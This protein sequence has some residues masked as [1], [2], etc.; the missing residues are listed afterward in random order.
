MVEKG[1]FFMFVTTYRHFPRHALHTLSCKVLC[2]FLLLVICSLPAAA[3]VNDCS[4]DNSITITPLHSSTIYLEKDKT[5]LLDMYFGYSITNNSGSAINDLWVRLNNFT[6]TGS[7][8]TLATYENGVS[9]IGSLENGATKV[10]YFYVK[11]TGPSANSQSHDVSLY[12]SNP[13]AALPPTATCKET[14]SITATQDTLDANANK[15]T[16]ITYSPATPEVGGELTLTVVGE[17]GEPGGS[18]GPFTLTPASLDSWRADIFELY[19]VQT[20]VAGVGSPFADSLDLSGWG[21]SNKAYTQVYKFRIKGTTASSTELKPV[22]YIISGGPVKYTGSYPASISPVSPPSSFVKISS[23]S[24]SP[25]CTANGGTSTMT[26]T[27]ENNGST[28]VTL[29][30]IAVTIPSSPAGASYVASSSVFDGSS[31]SEPALSGSILTWTGLF[32]IPA[33]TSKSLTFDVSTPNTDG[34]YIFSAIAHIDSTQVDATE[35]ITDDQPMTGLVCVGPTPTPTNTPTATPTRTPTPTPTTTPTPTAS[36]TPTPTRTP[37]PTATATATPTPTSTAAPTTAATPVPFATSAPSP[38]PTPVGDIDYDND[39]IPNSVEGPGD[40]D[41]DGI[42]DAYDLDSDNDGIPDIIEGGGSDANGDGIADSLVDSDGDGLVDMYDGDSGGTPQPTPDTDGD[43]KPDF[44]DVDS[45]GDGITDL[46]EGQNGVPVQPSGNDSDGDGLDDAFEVPVA[47]P[48]TDGDGRPDYRDIDSDG[49]GILDI[50]EGQ[51]SDPKSPSGIDSDNDGLDDAFEHKEPA[52][53]TDGDGKPDFRDLDS[54]DDGLPDIIEGQDGGG[55][56]KQPT[57]N[58]SDGDGLDDAFEGDDGAADTDGDHEPDFRDLDSDD[59]GKSDTFEAFDGNPPAREG[60]N[61]GDGID[62]A[63]KRYT[64]N[65]ALLN[66][67]WRVRPAS[68]LCSRI[69]THSK[70]KAAKATARILS[71]RL[72]RFYVRARDCGATDTG[73][74]WRAGLSER[75]KFEARI[76]KLFGGRVYRCPNGVCVKYNMLPY[77]RELRLRANKLYYLAQES[78]RTSIKFCKPVHDP[79]APKDK[80][81]RNGDYLDMLLNRLRAL[82]SRIHRC[83]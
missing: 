34:S 35:D 39:G 14:L 75:K 42:P 36:A 33:G 52:P 66:R 31:I 68:S 73:P 6:G 50:T 51:G 78:K 61:D 11:A 28:A 49:D 23:L 1:T 82:P 63:F 18:P 83:N 47:I 30:D 67:A 40:T 2:A 65:P 80:R 54:D 26:L 44:Q 8:F 60:D 19:S 71:D 59:D 4:A 10:V 41:G 12:P 43:G 25:Y 13:L 9:H 7:V 53:D 21:S 62:D 76:D 5:P 32:Q 45:D 37:T 69:I 17:T 48:D 29:D 24:G 56:P 79:K 20:T 22:N 58:D 16:S 64:I 70:V 77:L 38:T 81:L 46:I 3:Q 55:D 15:I 57:G 72:E 74:K 27:I